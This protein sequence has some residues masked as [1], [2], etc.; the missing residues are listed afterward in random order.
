MLLEM[1]G[2]HSLPPIQ[3]LNIDLSFTSSVTLG[4]LLQLQFPHLKN[5]TISLHHGAGAQ[6][7]EPFLSALLQDPDSTLLFEAARAEPSE[8]EGVQWPQAH[9]SPCLRGPPLGKQT[10]SF[11]ASQ[12]QPL[13]IAKCKPQS[14]VYQGDRS[15]GARPEETWVKMGFFQKR[16]GV[17][18][19][20]G[21]RGPQKLR[22]TTWD[23]LGSPT[24]DSR[25][26]HMLSKAFE[27]LDFRT[28]TCR[29]FPFVSSLSSSNPAKS[30]ENVWAG[31]RLGLRPHQHHH[32]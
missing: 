9:H 13:A 21:D 28:P 16:V 27:V 12:R 3:G 25:A 30:E 4:N 24:R 32:P 5:E 8:K 18:R 15:W 2:Q 10:G 17:E 31:G 1:G 26:L 11:R 20:A 14:E 22:L 19:A 7:Q 29:H 6:N 23:S